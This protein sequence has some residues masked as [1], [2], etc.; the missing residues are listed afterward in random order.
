[1]AEHRLLPARNR[2]RRGV[3]VA[4]A[5]D[6][7]RRDGRERAK[8]LDFEIFSVDVDAEMLLEPKE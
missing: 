1:M 3:P 6:D 5:R 2:T 8:V 7:E 4:S